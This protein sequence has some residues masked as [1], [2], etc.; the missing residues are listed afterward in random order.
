MEVTA[1]YFVSYGWGV[2]AIVLFFAAAGMV[3]VG[4]YIVDWYNEGA[5][6]YYAEVKEG[7]KW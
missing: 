2:A 3:R 7:M 5:T 6:D 1:E 4:A